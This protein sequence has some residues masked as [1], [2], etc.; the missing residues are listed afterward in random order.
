M[1]VKLNG[2]EQHLYAHKPIH[3][4]EKDRYGNYKG[5][6]DWEFL[7]PDDW[8]LHVGTDIK[9]VAGDGPDIPEDIKSLFIFK[10][11]GNP[12]IF[13]SWEELQQSL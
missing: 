6:R 2:D 7:D 12:R 9:M 10:L 1:A 13:S 5:F 4:E 3:K 11:Q 8:G